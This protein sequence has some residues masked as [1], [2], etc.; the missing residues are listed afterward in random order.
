MYNN[1]CVI[2]NSIKITEGTQNATG[3]ET[4]WGKK[5]NQ[6]ILCYCYNSE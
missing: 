3:N 2:I 4:S 1:Y 6:K 5:N